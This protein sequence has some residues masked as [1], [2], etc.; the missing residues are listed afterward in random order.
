MAT[1]KVFITDYIT[2]PD[3][4]RA[5]LGEG[6]SIECLNTEDEAEFPDSIEEEADALLVWH[7]RI[8]E[9][10]IR[11]LKK[12]RVIVRYGVGY[13]NVDF[14]CAQRY[15][16]PFCNTPDYGIH[17]VA[18]TTCGMIL[19]FI[20]KI[21]S[22]HHSAQRFS[23]G[24]QEHTQ[25]PIKRSTQHN[26]GIIGI[27]RI[28]SAVALRMKA[29]G[30]SIGFYDPYVP[31]GYEKTL[32][33]QRF[34]SREELLKFSSIVSLHVPLNEETRWMVDERFIQNLNDNT[35]LINTARGKIVKDLD[36]LYDGLVSSKLAAVG[37][38]V[39]PEEPPLP[40]ERLIQAWKDVNSDF[41]QRIIINPHTS[42]F[43]D[44]AWRE[45][46]EK[47]AENVKRILEGK[48]PRNLIT[49]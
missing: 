31:S 48:S 4:E 20:R 41:H 30:I 39:L 49:S 47:A 14:R 38:D 34:E 42:Y 8:T 27:G 19:A 18:D 11:R 40:S 22:Y 3:I 37:L 44:Q 32:G 5:V 10:T 25:P 28:G 43:S 36:V 21:F 2:S 26:L 12:C 9:K 15:G 24:W 29:F 1:I 16:I 6:V 45:M 33:V 46:R 13:D 23:S 7:A 35:T 17:E